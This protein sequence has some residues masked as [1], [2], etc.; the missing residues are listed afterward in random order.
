MGAPDNAVRYVQY[1]LA[2]T[3]QLDA[4]DSI[5]FSEVL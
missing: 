1:G 5:G 4:A 3:S 2:G